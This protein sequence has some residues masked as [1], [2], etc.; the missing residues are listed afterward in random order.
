MAMKGLESLALLDPTTAAAIQAQ[1]YKATPNSTSGVFY[2]GIPDPLPSDWNADQLA[3]LQIGALKALAYPFYHQLNQL[4]STWV[5]NQLSGIGLYTLGVDYFQDSSGH[6][7]PWDPTNNTSSSVNS[8]PATIGQLKAVFSLDF[9]DPN[10]MENPFGDD[11]GDK[12]SNYQEA[13]LFTDPQRTDTDSDGIDD[14]RET[15]F[16]LDP[17]AFH[18]P[19]DI[20]VEFARPVIRTSIRGFQYDFS[21]ETNSQGVDD[22]GGWLLDK[23]ADSAYWQWNYLDIVELQTPRVL[24]DLETALF[25][26]SFPNQA[27]LSD[28]KF[29]NRRW[30]D[31]VFSAQSTRRH[32]LIND[33]PPASLEIDEWDSVHCAYMLEVPML[34]PEARSFKALKIPIRTVREHSFA[35]FDYHGDGVATP[36]PGQSQEE[37][38]LEAFI[39]WRVAALGISEDRVIESN[40]VEILD[41]IVPANETKSQIEPIFTLMGAPVTGSYVVEQELVLAPEV[42]KLFPKEKDEEGSDIEGSDVVELGPRLTP[43]VEVN[44]DGSRIAYREIEVKFHSAL[45]G[46]K[47]QWELVPLYIPNYSPEGP[48]LPPKFKGNYLSAINPDDRNSFSE[49]LEFGK[50]NYKT[51]TNRTSETKIGQDGYSSIRVNIPPIGF[52]RAR[53]KVMIE[54]TNTQFDLIDMEVPGIVVIDP[55]HGG[56]DPGA[57]GKPDNSV[58]EAHLAL[59]YGLALKQELE[60][61][62]QAEKRNFRIFMT[63]TTDGFVALPSRPT[64]AKTEGADLFVSIHFNAVSSTT[65]RGTEYLTRSPSVNFAVNDPFGESVMNATLAAIQ[66]TDPAG[67]ARS[68]KPGGWAVLSDAHFN[69]SNSYR[70]IRS[71]LIEVEFISHATALDAV[72]LTKNGAAHPSGVAIKDKFAEDVS[73]VIFDQIFTYP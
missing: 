40:G 61:K 36:G 1:L 19:N 31:F 11:D 28:S 38:D 9:L 32:I 8:A 49:S 44:P 60:M 22:D 14:F 72:R 21:D 70:P 13:L 10:L 53:I 50:N 59:P 73:E 57:E 34:L 43:F 33:S 56:T 35:Q 52:D 16:G 55:G 15:E 3:P 45:M 24:W 46:K 7:Y 62:F 48:N 26:D 66:A 64:K 30:P 4:D 2:P 17:T 42:V 12:L 67:K 47:V 27:T 69:I 58:K 37:A 71:T 68:P 5:Q 18:Y 63:R 41:F 54:G 51:L 23:D 6:F 65:V 29:G 39:A 25:V 20:E